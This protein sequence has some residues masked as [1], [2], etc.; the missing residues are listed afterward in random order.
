ML[1]RGACVAAVAGV[2]LACSGEGGG[3][4]QWYQHKSIPSA[5]AA[6]VE[7]ESASESSAGAGEQADD[8]VEDTGRATDG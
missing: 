5:G 6:G 4:G 8:S 1:K 2:L 3:G 7:D